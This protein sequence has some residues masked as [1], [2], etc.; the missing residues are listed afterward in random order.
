MSDWSVLKLDYET[1]HF[2]LSLY[3]GNEKNLRTLEEKLDIQVITRDGWISFKGA[4]EKAL[5]AQR[6]F[7]DL[8]K[9]IRGGSSI[10]SVSFLVTCRRKSPLIYARSMTLFQ[11]CYS[12]PMPKNGWKMALSK[13]HLWHI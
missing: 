2:L 5:K 7:E 1:P 6:L 3:A 11:I 10:S 8:E 9:V 4:K 12:P 13:S